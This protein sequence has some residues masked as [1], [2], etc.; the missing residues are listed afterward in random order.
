MY[1][2]NIE[3]NLDQQLEKLNEEYKEFLEGIKKQDPENTIEEFF[4]LIQVSL[5]VI[6]ILG[7]EKELEKGQIKHDKKLLQRGWQKCS[8]DIYL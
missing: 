5:G 6:K 7:L 8:R 2:I 4:D 1:L 3:T